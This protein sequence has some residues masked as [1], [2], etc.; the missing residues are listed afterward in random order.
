MLAFETDQVPGTTGVEGYVVFLIRDRD[1]ALAD[2]VGGHP[3]THVDDRLREAFQ[4]QRMQLLD[5]RPARAG[6]RIEIEPYLGIQ[7]FASTGTH[8]VR[9]AANRWSAGRYWRRKPYSRTTYWGFS[10]ASGSRSFASSGSGPWTSSRT[11]SEIFSASPS[12]VPTLSRCANRP[13]ASA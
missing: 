12:R 8:T 5:A 10:S 9:P 13:S 2:A 4:Y 7:L 6:D 1:P 3:V 11:R